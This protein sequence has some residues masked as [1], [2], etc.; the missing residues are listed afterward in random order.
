MDHAGIATQAVVER[1]LR[2]QSQRTASA[3]GTTPEANP[4]LM[5]GRH[6]F[7]EKVWKWKNKQSTLIRQQLDSLGLSLD[8]SREFFT[9]DEV[10]TIELHEATQLPVPG[11]T[12][13]QMFGIMDYFAY[14][15][16]NRLLDFSPQFIRDTFM[17][18]GSGYGPV[19]SFP[20]LDS[21]SRAMAQGRISSQGL[22]GADLSSG[23]SPRGIAPTSGRHLTNRDP[24]TFLLERQ[25]R[26]RINR[27]YPDGD[28]SEGRMTLITLAGRSLRS[29]SRQDKDDHMST[30][31]HSKSPTAPNHLPLLQQPI[32]S[33]L[34][35]PKFTIL[36][37][38]DEVNHP[39]GASPSSVSNKSSSSSS[40]N[41]TGA[42]PQLS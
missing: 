42:D 29:G 30:D 7:V 20:S 28:L 26:L 10:D 22:P 1:E 17:G 23:W 2:K 15:L 36:P 14:P 3:P 18:T 33:A 35:S 4:R 16:C 27:S 24:G 25:S 38:P 39:I 34:Q 13:P 11:Y 19:S 9:L 40:P 6:E 21:A 12:E 31:S 37:P 8:W 5:L 32:A 41:P